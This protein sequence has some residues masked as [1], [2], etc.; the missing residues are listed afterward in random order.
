MAKGLKLFYGTLTVAEPAA[1]LLEGASFVEQVRTAP[2]Y[3][4]FSL[5]GFPV[6]VEDVAAGRAIGAQ[7]WQVPAALW[8]DIVASEPPEMTGQ[9]VELEDGRRV[10]TLVGSLAFVEARMGAEVTEH[11]SWKAYRL[12]QRSNF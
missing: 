8:A 11:G 7:V 6:L 12:S 2:R 5:S 9:A 3:R 1:A 4:L 10:E